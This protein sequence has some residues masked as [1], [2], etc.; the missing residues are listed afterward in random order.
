MTTAIKSISLS[1]ELLT[2]VEKYKISLS[3][4]VRVG[5]SV[6]LADLGEHQFL[7]RVN[8]GRKVQ[9]MAGIIDEQQTKLEEMQNVLEKKGYTA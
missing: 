8:L 3:E 7:N 4:A 6:M 2:W 1:L 5:I 9:K